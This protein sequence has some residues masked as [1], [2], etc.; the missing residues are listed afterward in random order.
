[1]NLLGGG[2][3]YKKWILIGLIPLLVVTVILYFFFS[4]SNEDNNKTINGGG[5][6]EIDKGIDTG[7]GG[8]NSGSEEVINGEN[9][10]TPDVKPLV[11][12]RGKVKSFTLTGASATVKMSTGKKN[13]SYKIVTQTVVFDSTT[14]KVIL[15]SEISKG[16]E[17]SVYST[18]DVDSRTKKDTVVSVIVLGKDKVDYTSATEVVKTKKGT[19]LV[20]ALEGVKYRLPSKPSIRNAF[21]G[22]YM[23]PSDIK[24]GDSVFV[25]RGK[26]S[27]SDKYEKL[28]TTGVK[29]PK[30]LKQSKLKTVSDS[31]LKAL[32]DKDLK[33]VVVYPNNR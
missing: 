4:G 17:A 25:Y 12:Q 14:K 23:Y 28:D 27:D 33:S 7:E 26:R 1:M 19:Y 6:V 31:S 10:G 32:K 29:L 13:H 21:T 2:F 16:V 22:Y 5:S 30:Q 18:E 20:D 8:F 24:S 15:P 3:N 11:S 9:V